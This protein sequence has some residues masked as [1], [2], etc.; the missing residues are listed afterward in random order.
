M[1]NKQWSDLY[2]AYI[3][4][5]WAAPYIAWRMEHT[6]LFSEEKTTILREVEDYIVK[7]E[8]VI[9]SSAHEFLDD[10][11]ELYMI[12]YPDKPFKDLL[13]NPS[14]SD[15]PTLRELL[16]NRFHLLSPEN[17]GTKKKRY[18]F[19]HQHFRDFL[20]ALH[21]DNALKI[22]FVTSD[23]TGNFIIP[24]EIRNRVL[25]VYIT[26][27]LG[28]YY[29][30]YQNQK[31]VIVKNNLHKLLDCLRGLDPTQVGFAV[32]NVIGVW[33]T[34]R[35][36]HIVGE[37]L[38]NLNLTKVPMNGIFFSTP[39][40]ATCF[41]KS[42]FSDA[43]FLPQGHSEE[44]ESAVYSP[45]GSCILTASRDGTVREWDRKTGACL[46]TYKG[47]TDFV[48]SATYSSDGQRILSASGDGTVRE[49]DRKTG[50]DIH[51][52]KGHTRAVRSAVYSP[53]GSC[54]LTAS[55]DGTVREWDRKTGADIHTYRGLNNWM[56]SAVYSPDGSCI[57]T[58]SWGCEIREW[59]RKTGVCLHTYKERSPVESAVYSPDGS[60]ILTALNDCTVMELDRKT[61]ECLWLTPSYVGV[62]I[63]NCSFKDCVF[64]NEN[65]KQIIRLYGGKNLDPFQ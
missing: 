5:F 21:I 2:S 16:V 9:H 25:P 19:R 50:A 44:I 57:L 54:I 55:R 1:D 7:N 18:S 26:D 29:E 62:F 32:N 63:E 4:L 12:R 39:I 42:F 53:D 15:I 59:D 48:N 22:A 56:M 41:N 31:Q 8:L 36:G 24:E 46:H 30:D 65:L 13:F 17:A 6:G 3:A 20:S 58:G 61:G 45:D 14:S 51:T 11:D 38:S 49:W 64:D 10:I 40:V 34:S 23:R 43:T 28:G 27:M 52:Y 37:D 47:H 35:V 60:Y 33:R